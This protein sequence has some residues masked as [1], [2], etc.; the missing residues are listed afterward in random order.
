MRSNPLIVSWLVLVA[1]G[2]SLGA[3]GR[4]VPLIEAVKKGEEQA[5]RRLAQQGQVNTAEIDGTTALHWAAYGE[6]LASVD[7]LIAAG[8][9]AKAANRY[10]V[11]PISLA[12]LRG[13]AVIIEHLLAAGADPN[14]TVEGGETPL[15]SAARAG[16]A[17]AVKALLAHGADVNAR[18]S[19][20]GQNALMWAAVEGHV[21]VIQV[22]AAAG[23]DVNGRAAAPASITQGRARANGGPN[24]GTSGR[25]DALTPLLFAARRGQAGAV[26]ALLDAGA[27]IN[28]TAADG[29]GPVA[30]AAANAHYDLAL[31]LLDKG[32]DPQAATKGWTLLHQIAR[33]RTPHVRRLPPPPGYD[34]EASLT[35]VKKLI[36]RGVDVNT[37]MTVDVNDGYRHFD[38]RVGATAFFLASKSADL[39]MMR[40]LLEKGADAGLATDLGDTPLIGLSGLSLGAPGE[41]GLTDAQL[42]EAVTLILEHAGG[43]LNAANREG[44]TALHGAAYRGSLGMVKLLVDRGARLDLR[45]KTGFTPW[46]I[47][48]GWA[49]DNHAYEQP[50]AEVLLRKLM[51]ERGVPITGPRGVE[52]QTKLQQ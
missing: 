27:R 36:E 31:L 38:K 4:E 11:T 9:N 16:R 32:A 28:D 33:T 49:P 48:T 8:A 26:K 37:R 35:L 12:A 30:L 52:L 23:A 15:M 14:V 2:V 46:T 51:E 7:I 1:C 13:N 6:H 25:I 34:A 20:R 21:S 42:I 24:M 47:A 22:L 5:V 41:D 45:T 17:D 3:A 29:S 19:T 40:L 10:G 39:K 50:E 18:E 43:T 44:F